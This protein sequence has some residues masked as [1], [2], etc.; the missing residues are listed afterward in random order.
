[1]QHSLTCLTWA[2]SVQQEGSGSG[3]YCDRA[4]ARAPG[5]Q[6]WGLSTFSCSLAESTQAL[7][8]RFVDGRKHVLSFRRRAQ[9]LTCL[10]LPLWKA[11]PNSLTWNSKQHFWCPF[12][13]ILEECHLSSVP[14]EAEN[15]SFHSYFL[16]LFLVCTEV[17][18]ICLHI[19]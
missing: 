12:F 7:E 15:L 13:Y 16:E 17:C 18:S 1:M 14:D 10:W 8:A 11:S 9:H 6:N 4:S 5:E 2:G 3:C 19:F